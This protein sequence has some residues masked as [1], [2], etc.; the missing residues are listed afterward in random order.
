MTASNQTPKGIGKQARLS[1]QPVL[2]SLCSMLP[3]LFIIPFA[4]STTPAHAAKTAPLPADLGGRY[5]CK[6]QDKAEGPYDGVV[7][8]E[9][10][11]AQSTKEYTAYRFKLTVPGFG[12]YPGHASAKGADMAIYFANTDQKDKDYGTGLARFDMSSKGVLKFTKF[13]YQPEYKGGN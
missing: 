8:L 12:E 1:A 3:A 7:E 11:P 2:R 10:V 5:E 9:K 4:L 6:G 13:Y